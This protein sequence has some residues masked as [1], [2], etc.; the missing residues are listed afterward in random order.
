MGLGDGYASYLLASLSLFLFLCT[1]LRFN[2]KNL[3]F[4]DISFFVAQN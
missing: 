4:Y 3:L 1:S 2:F